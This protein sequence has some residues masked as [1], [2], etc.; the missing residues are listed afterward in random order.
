MEEVQKYQISHLVLLKFRDQSHN[1]S[2]HAL[3]TVRFHLKKQSMALEKKKNHTVTYH[4][5]IKI[6]NAINLSKLFLPWVDAKLYQLHPTR[7]LNRERFYKIHKPQHS[8]HSSRDNR[9]LPLRNSKKLQPTVY[10][11]HALNLISTDQ[12][13]G[14][15]MQGWKISSTEAQPGKCIRS[16]FLPSSTNALVVQIN[17][18][19]FY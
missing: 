1:H 3:Q 4:T 8:Y 15:F 5:I 7:F 10:K 16:Y 12:Y 9:T 19:R 13:N 6:F 18:K 14:Y 17:M 11:S 2:A